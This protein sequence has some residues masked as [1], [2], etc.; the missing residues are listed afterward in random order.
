[1]KK[2]ILIAALAVFALNASAAGG[3][4]S[5]KPLDNTYVTLQGGVY[6]PL[7]GQNILKDARPVIRL[8]VNKF[9]NT[10]VG[11]SIWA[12]TYI[13]NNNYN[14]YT[15][16]PFYDFSSLVGQGNKTLFDGLNV[17]VNG[18][19]NL[20]N[21]F[22]GYAGAPRFFEVIAEA[23]VGYF[24]QFGTW[25]VENWRATSHSTIDFALD[26][27][28]NL[29]EKLQLGIR[30]EVQFME[31]TTHLYRKYAQ[32]QLTAGIA[33]NLGG[34]FTPIVPRDQAE[35]D[36]LNGKINDLRSELDAKDRMIAGLNK[37]IND[38][39][40][41]LAKKPVVAPAAAP[42]KV[43]LQPSVIFRQ[44]KS[45]IDANEFAEIEMVAKYMKNHP[46]ANIL[47]EGYASPEGPADLNQK[48]S[49]KRAEVVKNTLIKKY[50]IAAERLEAK[51]MG[52]TDKLFDEYDFNRVA[53]FIVK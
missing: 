30:P 38:L 33:Y 42:V 29:N 8:S 26:F 15:A 37:T 23:G 20:N 45:V 5:S 18:L 10:V 47:I 3:Y 12:Q 1:M 22:A 16:Y 52:I 36:A 34:V 27:N 7:S 50:G 39:K 11:A 17:G 28:F 4:K 24:H 35:I 48:L 49:E 53:M 9:F 13:N 31:R 2:L 6:E 40:A 43:A 19:V 32:V 44:G 21:L 14:N 41:E 25:G 46:D 51:G